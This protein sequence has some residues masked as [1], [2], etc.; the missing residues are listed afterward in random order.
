[1]YIFIDFHWLI[2]ST[3]HPLLL[4]AALLTGFLRVMSNMMNQTPS[5]PCSVT[6]TYW[7][8]LFG[9]IA[10][11]FELRQFRIVL[12]AFAVDAIDAFLLELADFTFNE[13]NVAACVKIAWRNGED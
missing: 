7:L 6:G 13:E 2:D 10:L 3:L 4:V 8:S 1:M 9:L 5:F 12:D 11:H